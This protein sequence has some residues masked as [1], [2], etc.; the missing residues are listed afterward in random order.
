MCNSLFQLYVNGQPQGTRTDEVA[1]AKERL[2][3]HLGT[4][5]QWAGVAGNEMAMLDGNLYQIVSAD[6]PAVE[7]EA[8]HD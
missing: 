8:S 6:L 5:L 2:A 7:Y 1:F 4:E 3:H